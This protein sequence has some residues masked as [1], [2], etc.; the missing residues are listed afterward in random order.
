MRRP[1]RSADLLPAEVIGLRV[2]A[3]LERQNLLRREWGV[4]LNFFIPEQVLR[5]TLGS[6]RVMNEQLLH[7][8]LISSRPWRSIRVAPAPFPAGVLGSPFQLP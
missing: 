2:Q 1:F 4:D 3:R 8:V 6:S 7:M 5:V